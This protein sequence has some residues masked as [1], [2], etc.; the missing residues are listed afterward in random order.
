MK[1]FIS[2]ISLALF[3]I[4]L[5]SCIVIQL[6]GEIHDTIFLRHEGADMPVHVH[7]NSDNNTF[8]VVVHGAGSFG[9][10]F[11][12]GAFTSELEEDYVVVYFDQRGQGT[13]QGHYAQLDAEHTLDRMTTD[14]EALIDLLKFKYGEDIKLFVMGHSWGG[15]LS[16]TTLLSRDFENQI[17]GWINVAGLMD[18]PTASAY[19]KEILLRIADEQIDLNNSVADWQEIK[20]E[21][22][23]LD[24]SSDEGHGIV[25]SNAAKAVRLL[26]AD[27]FIRSTASTEKV[28]RAL[29]ENNPV[30]WQV[31]HFFNQPVEYAKSVNFS[32]VKSLKNVRVPSLFIY[33]KYDVSVPYIAGFD[34]YLNLGAPDKRFVLFESSMH[35]PHD[36]EPG[37]FA[38]E[39][40][41]FINLHN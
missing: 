20:D 12:D 14:L 16:G 39:V 31:S 10:A 35:H 19:R 34:A 30:S 25:L 41:L 37:K 15:L 8:L 22:F 27:D 36:T 21:L 1:T 23:A 28:Y 3:T 7:G 11:R 29:I 6:E 18:L 4:L 24:P 17:S 5:P 32:I 33:G 13:S 26:V 2:I 9:L 40:K 38:E